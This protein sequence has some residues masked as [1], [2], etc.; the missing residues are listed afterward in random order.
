MINP[1]FPFEL[2]LPPFFVD[3]GV[4]FPLDAASVSP[5]VPSACAAPA[6]HDPKTYGTLDGDNISLV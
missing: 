1:T 4:A 5:P 2:C 3:L 6:W